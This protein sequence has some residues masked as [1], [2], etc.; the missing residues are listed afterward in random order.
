MERVN[1]D[2]RFEGEK[3]SP[4]KLKELTGLPIET[5]AEYGEIAAKGRFK[6]KSFPYGLALLR[7]DKHSDKDIT[8]ILEKYLNKL[9]DKKKEIS[10]SGVDDII[11]DVET[12]PFKESGFSFENEILF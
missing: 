12:P 11:I 7:V 8:Y 1:I 4:R 10:K 2:I 5:L 6:G 9:L 3:F